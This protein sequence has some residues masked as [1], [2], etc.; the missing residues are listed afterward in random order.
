VHDEIKDLLCVLIKKVNPHALVTKEQK[1]T[2][3]RKPNVP[4][5]QSASQQSNGD[6][7]CDIMVSNNLEVY[8]IDLSFANPACKSAITLGSNVKE[9]AA[10][11]R[12]EREKV[13]KYNKYLKPEAHNLFVPFIG[14]TTGRLSGLT[15]KFIR[16]LCKIDKM[17]LEASE[18]VKWE[19][20]KFMEEVS[21]SLAS[22]NAE[23]M[24]AGR[25]MGHANRIY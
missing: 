17:D 1:I 25:A 14:E 2:Q 7:I 10:A 18:N 12:R 21:I 5:S 16:K 9:S 4:V 23:V 3:F 24:R 15:E 11:S 6:L 22:T 8:F 20:I 19:R 13:L